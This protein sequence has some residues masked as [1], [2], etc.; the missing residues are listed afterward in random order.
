MAPL[1]RLWRTIGGKSALRALCLGAVCAL[2]AAAASFAWLVFVKPHDRLAIVDPGVNPRQGLATQIVLESAALPAAFVPIHKRD[3]YRVEPPDI[4]AITFR[5]ASADE[6]LRVPN[7]EVLVKPD[8]SVELGDLDSMQ[9]AGMTASQI[10]VAIA[11][12]V[13]ATGRR[14]Q[15]EVSVLTQNSKV[16]YLIFERAGE[17]GDSVSRYPVV[18]NETV[19]DALGQAS[20]FDGFAG[21]KIWI[22]RPQP[23]GPPD[24]VLPVDAGALLDGGPALLPGDR[25]FVSELPW[26]E[27][28]L[29]R[30]AAMFHAIGNDFRNDYPVKRAGYSQ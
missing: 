23:S 11:D 5:G 24:S 17:G 1:V 4:L 6:T 14:W 18:G 30:A 20:E 12:R 22:A 7:G 8:G 13:R 2:I 16:Y 28:L 9:V 21:K 3:D 29:E 15:V 26:W 25:I 19:L 10:R 27:Q